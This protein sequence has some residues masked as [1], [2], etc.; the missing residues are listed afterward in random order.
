MADTSLKSFEQNIE[1][2]QQIVKDLDEGTLPLDEG[3]KLYKEGVDCAKTCR[4]LLD[5][6]NHQLTLWR[7]GEEKSLKLD[8]TE[9]K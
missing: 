6:A 5:D 2:L 7:E 9:S 8:E 1:R 3:M 4:K